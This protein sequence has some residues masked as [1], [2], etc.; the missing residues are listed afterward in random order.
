MSDTAASE[1]DRRLEV[2][3]EKRRR[4]GVASWALTPSFPPT[5][6]LPFT[7]AGEFGIRNLYE[8]QILMYRPLYWFGRSGLP[9]VDFDLSLA[10]LPEWRPDGRTVTIRLKDWRWSN[11]D[12]ITADNVMLFMHLLEV[13]KAQHGGYTPGYF[14]DNLAS[15]SKVAPNEVRFTFD[16]VYS[17]N[18]VLMNELSLIV[19]MPALWDRTAAGPADA[20]HRLEDAQA[21]YE[22]LWQ[23]TNDL[24]GLDRDPLWQVVSGPWKLK[25][26]SLDGHITLVAN[27]AYSGP[28]QP[29][30]DEFRLVPT[31]S[32]EAEYRSLEAG[33]RGPDSIQVGFLPFD[34][35]A[36]PA[37]DPMKGGPSPLRD[38][39]LVP[40]VVFGI[41]YFPLNQN[42]PTVGPIFRQLYFRQALQS[43]IDQ[44]WAMREIYQGYGWP[45]YG[46]VPATPPSDLLSPRARSNQYPFSLERARRLLIENGWDVSQ[47]PGRCLRPG[48]GSGRAGEGVPE[49]AVL[50]FQMDYAQGHPTL[51]RIFE[52]LRADAARVGIEIKLREKPGIEIAAQ[53]A[54]CKPSA[55]TP[56]TWQLSSWNGG[57]VYGPGFYPTGE[58]QF[59]SGAG[60]NW[61]SFS[62]PHTDEL[63]DRTVSSDSKD[64]FYAY[65][66]YLGQQLPVIWMPN[67]PLRLLMVANDLRG[68][69]PINPY[70]MLT[71]ENWY[72]VSD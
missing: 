38:Y 33:G 42:N 10:E 45:T 25:R 50:S 65:Q 56:C 37:S 66:D 5:I 28:N 22:Y 16:R 71:P 31:E 4:G 17:R 8:Y 62:D 24:P 7:P 15:Y 64:D 60:V 72:Y 21:V 57:W 44:E 46:P 23:R 63:I 49:G 41:H 3:E 51:T 35:V 11:G 43:L 20:T 18:W 67:F 32:D 48:A 58:F 12:R 30:L 39:R 2:P 14:P 68:V 69:E 40:Q 19:P 27:R 55:T 13:N 47:T 6:T 36:E 70:G 59:K 52:K 61:G 53:V 34:H 9:Q 1:L 26:Y 54:P 29:Y